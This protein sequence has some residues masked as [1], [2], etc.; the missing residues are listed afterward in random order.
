MAK[1]VKQRFIE[2]LEEELVQQCK[3]AEHWR[4]LE[5][6][7][8]RLLDKDEK[9]IATASEMVARCADKEDELKSFITKIRNL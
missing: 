4:E 2:L 3:L 7:G 1:D 5:N 8:G 6:A 9:V